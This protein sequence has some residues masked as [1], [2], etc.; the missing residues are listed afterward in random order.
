MDAHYPGE[1]AG[2]MAVAEAL[3]GVFSPAGKLTYTVM[4][5]EFDTLSDFSSMNMSTPPGRTYKYYPTSPGYPAAL[6]DFGH[7]LTYSSFNFS[8]VPAEAGDGV[9]TRSNVFLTGG[10]AQ[11]YTVKITNTGT[12]DSDEVCLVF[13]VPPRRAGVPTPKR[14]LLDFVSL[15]N[16]QLLTPTHFLTGR[17]CWTMAGACPRGE[18]LQRIAD[19]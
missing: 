12:M 10:S 13:M 14:Q 18:G 4:P 1:I 2:A 6:W 17:A 16:D 9:S 8:M 7:G 5:K 11:S 19:L 15:A 3:Y